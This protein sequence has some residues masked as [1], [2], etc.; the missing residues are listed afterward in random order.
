MLLIFIAVYLSIVVKA[1]RRGK[2]GE[3]RKTFQQRF[4]V[5]FM[6]FF[7]DFFLELLSCI[8][9]DGNQLARLLSRRRASVAVELFLCIENYRKWGLQVA[10]CRGRK[11]ETMI[12]IQGFRH[13]P[14]DEV[15]MQTRSAKILQLNWTG[16]EDKSCLFWK[17]EDAPLPAC[18][19]YH[20]SSRTQSVDINSITAIFLPSVHGDRR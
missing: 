7:N 19:P 10:D 20:D 11:I 12:E 9:M 2:A 8:F 5:Q 4:H 16:G 18:L 14:S 15:V 17:L 6:I 3:E 1:E 13:P